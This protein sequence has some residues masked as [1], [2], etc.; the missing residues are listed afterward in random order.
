[1][2]KIKKDNI[3]IVP[4]LK[5]KEKAIWNAAL[6]Y[7]DKRNDK[8]H[9]EFV[10]YFA[11]KLTELLNGNRKITIPGA[12]LHDVG[13]SQLT[14]SELKGFYSSIGTNKELKLRKKHQEEGVKL[15][16][17]LLTKCEYPRKLIK[18]I[19]EII[20]QHDTRKGFYSN[21][22]GIVR[23]SDKLWRFTY[24]AIRIAMRE[25]G[26]TFSQIKRFMSKEINRKGFFYSEIARR[27][28]LLEL[29]TLSI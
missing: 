26:Y 10:T 15:V 29:N 12:I 19:L 17:D 4:L 9:A 28:A 16:K 13:W 3:N 11:L 25:K 2:I 23:D 24:P 20:S 8:G 7:Q 18:E 21:E 5:P 14:K 27:I 22:D 6:P 1:M